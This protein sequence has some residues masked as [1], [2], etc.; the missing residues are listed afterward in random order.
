M[1]SLFHKRKKTA[2][3]NNSRDGAAGLPFSTAAGA[4]PV[5]EAQLKKDVLS[6]N[7]PPV[8]DSARVWTWAME[9]L[10]AY[11]EL[12]GSGYLLK[13]QINLVENLFSEFSSHVEEYLQA[14]GSNVPIMLVCNRHLQQGNPAEAER[15]AKPYLDYLDS[16]GEIFT[17]GHLELVG[18]VD[19]A[20][21]ESVHGIITDGQIRPEGVV[22]FLLLNEQICRATLIKTPEEMD[23]KNR[24]T[25]R[26]MT[27][28]SKLS[29]CDARVWL[30]LARAR[31]SGDTPA[32]RSTIRRAMEYALDEHTL[33]EA[34]G[35]LAMSRL[36]KE[37]Q[38]ASALCT[39]AQSCGEMAIAPRYLMSKMGIPPMPRPAAEKLVREA[40]IQIGLSPRVKE[41]LQRN[42]AE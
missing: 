5:L 37:P 31:K 13:F 19:R 21:Y 23:A 6:T 18:P 41:I 25:E 22:Q 40:G 34:Y 26:R 7:T 12:E 39:M 29:P 35:E 8:S 1:F 10:Q 17:D 27:A 36:A 33:G 24:E 11:R 28:A 38:L 16:H 15:V 9:R 4:D 30:E 42:G 2:G 3:E 14:T 20:L 32:F